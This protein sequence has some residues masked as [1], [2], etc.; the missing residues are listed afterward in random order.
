MSG[1]L[2]LRRFRKE[3]LSGHP[4][5]E[6]ALIRVGGRAVAKL[7]HP[8]IAQVNLLSREDGCLVLGVDDV[9]GLDLATVLRLLAVRGEHLPG[10][11]AVAIVDGVLG[12]L[13]CAHNHRSC[14]GQAAACFHLALSPQQ[15]RLG[16]RSQI[17]VEEVPA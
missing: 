6:P 13:T 11:L 16:W 14:D 2:T 3:A 4:G 5:L 1:H 9:L 15:V 17:Q 7:V 8:N 12:A 10:G